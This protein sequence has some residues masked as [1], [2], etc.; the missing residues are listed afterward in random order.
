MYIKEEKVERKNENSGISMSDIDIF[1]NLIVKQEKRLETEKEEAKERR[2]IAQKNYEKTE[3]YKE[4]RKNYRKTEAYKEYQKNYQK[5]EAYKEKQKN[6]Q[7][8]EAFKEQKRKYRKTDAFKE[9]RMEAGER[10]RQKTKIQ[11]ARANPA[12]TERKVIWQGVL[13]WEVKTSDTQKLPLHIPCQ[14]STTNSESQLSV[15]FFLPD[16]C[17]SFCFFNYY[18]FVCI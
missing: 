2:K 13:E 10:L 1:E 7:K 4:K 15:Y 6:Y 9:K 16:F 8:T 5:T 12:P 11:T 18:V 3:A 14:V 17:V